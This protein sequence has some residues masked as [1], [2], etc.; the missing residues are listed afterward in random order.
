MLN[1]RK[2]KVIVV[3]VVL[4]L[5]VLFIYLFMSKNSEPD[6]TNPVIGGVTPS[7]GGVAPS[8]GASQG[9]QSSTFWQSEQGSYADSYDS[10]SNNE[11][12]E[13]PVLY[14]PPQNAPGGTVTGSGQTGGSTTMPGTIPP[15]QTP[16]GNEPGTSTEKPEIQ[17]YGEEVLAAFRPMFDTMHMQEGFFGAFAGATSS[18]NVDTKAVGQ[19]IATAYET[20]AQKIAGLQTPRAFIEERDAVVTAFMN[21]G[22]EISAMAE[23][24]PGDTQKSSAALERYSHTVRPA[25]DA[26]IDILE[27]IISAGA[28]LDGVTYQYTN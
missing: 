23:I 26:Y 2:K 9:G 5:I 22:A 28:K 20:T 3:L 13:V 6:Q 24:Q 14:Y 27:K 12:K 7:T 10:F 21:I 1:T 15:A 17:V 25:Y 11:P 4:V 19:Q 8:G 18:Q 16:S